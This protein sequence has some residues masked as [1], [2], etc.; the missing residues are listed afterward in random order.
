MMLN[1]F[2]NH[3][4]AMKPCTNHRIFWDFIGRFLLGFHGSSHVFPWLSSQEASIAETLEVL[5]G[6]RPSYEV[7]VFSAAGGRWSHRGSICVYI[8]IYIC[9]HIY[10]YVYIYIYICVYIY[11]YICVYIY[12]FTYVYI[13]IYL[14]MCIY[15]YLHMY[16]YLY[17]SNRLVNGWD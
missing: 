15:I 9:I 17:T 12:I 5:D 10:I 7:P 3:D 11:I 13:Y 6:L 16:I 4:M 1:T 2:K 8:Y 14:H